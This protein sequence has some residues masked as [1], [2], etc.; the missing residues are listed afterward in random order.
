MAMCLKHMQSYDEKQGGFCQQ[1]REEQTKLKPKTVWQEPNSF[2]EL[3]EFSE[4]KS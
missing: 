4:G 1:C 2:S 3:N